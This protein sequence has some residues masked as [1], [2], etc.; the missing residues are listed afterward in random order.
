MFHLGE[1]LRE[2]ISSCG[3]LDAVADHRYGK[4]FSIVAKF[5][6]PS[7]HH[8][9]KPTLLNIP[10]QYHYH[11]G[12]VHPHNHKLSLHEPSFSSQSAEQG[13]HQRAP[14]RLEET[15]NEGVT[16][17]QIEGTKR[18]RAVSVDMVR[19]GISLPG[20]TTMGPVNAT[21]V[22]SVGGPQSVFVNV[23]KKVPIMP[24]GE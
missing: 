10:Q 12:P 1:P 21:S 23:P 16:N 2:A 18:N 20:A 3:L 11:Q 24:Q 4:G 5:L 17:K 14:P 9:P 7:S 6:T 19:R 22:S 15:I 8:A 13:T